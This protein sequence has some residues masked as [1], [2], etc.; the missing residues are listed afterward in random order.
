VPSVL[1]LSNFRRLFLGGRG[2]P[3]AGSAATGPEFE[4]ALHNMKCRRGRLRKGYIHAQEKR[5]PVAIGFVGRRRLRR[6]RRSGVKRRRSSRTAIDH[7]GSGNGTNPRE[8]DFDDQEAQSRKSASFAQKLRHAHYRGA[9]AAA[10]DMRKG[11]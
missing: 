6:A 2:C 10:L 4:L 8:V 5:R 9:A 3:S 11:E 7:D 1:E